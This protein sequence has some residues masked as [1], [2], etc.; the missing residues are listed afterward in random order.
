LAVV[1]LGALHIELAG[2]RCPAAANGI[3]CFQ[4]P[5]Q[6][7][8]AIFDDKCIMIPDAADGP[9]LSTHKKEFTL[10]LF[11]PPRQRLRS[12][13]GSDCGSLSLTQSNL[14]R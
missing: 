4:V 3:H 7:S 10:F 11:F 6:N 13:N 5:R 8:I 9:E 12:T 2:I 14:I 1:A